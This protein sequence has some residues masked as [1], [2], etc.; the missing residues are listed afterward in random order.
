M[1]FKEPEKYGDGSTWPEVTISFILGIWVTDRP[2]FIKNFKKRHK[3]TRLVNASDDSP[4][5]Y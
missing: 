1:Q 3:Q 4:H 5:E 2:K